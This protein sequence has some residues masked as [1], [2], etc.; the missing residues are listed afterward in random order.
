MWSI[1]IEGVVLPMELSW[2]ESP[3]EKSMNCPFLIHG[4]CNK[5]LCYE[6]K[7]ET[8]KQDFL[9]GTMS[10]FPPKVYGFA[11]HSFTGSKYLNYKRTVLW[12]KVLLIWKTLTLKVCRFPVLL[13]FSRCLNSFCVENLWLRSKIRQLI[14]IICLDLHC[15]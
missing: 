12:V 2:S 1:P 15:P 8:G 10:S 3:Q 4:I 13:A 9:D 14:F 5:K 11:R 7:D 6:D